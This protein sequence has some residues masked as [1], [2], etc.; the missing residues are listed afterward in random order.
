M[1]VD[2]SEVM[3]K[4]FEQLKPAARGL[5]GVIS[6]ILGYFL[7]IAH[8]TYVMLA[9]FII[10][11]IV[12]AYVGVAVKGE[13]FEFSRIWKETGLRMLVATTIIA[14]LFSLDKEHGQG[15]VQTYN[16]ANY[17][18]C[19]VLIINISKNAYLATGWKMFSFFGLF[20]Q[21]RVREQTGIDVKE[22]QA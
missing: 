8:L 14:L 13:R 6:A 7:P 22:E 15:F 9:C 21:Q 1:N 10:D 20:L 2:L 12:G 18:F 5:F 19:F 16:V 3:L 4:L 17:F 11:F